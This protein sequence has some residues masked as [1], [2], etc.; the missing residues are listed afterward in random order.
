MEVARYLSIVAIARP[1]RPR[2]PGDTVRCNRERRQLTK[3]MLPLVGEVP[4][5]SPGPGGLRNYY[6]S[7]LLMSVSCV[8][9]GVKAG[10]SRRD[11]VRRE[12]HGR[13]PA[14]R[15]T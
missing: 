14:R 8:N 11:E 10:N 7:V 5:R 2:S 1:P 9:Y 13:R 6:D 4:G 3:L 15:A 12:C